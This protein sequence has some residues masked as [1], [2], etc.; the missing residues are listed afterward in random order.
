MVNL[1]GTETNTQFA[2]PVQS[3]NHV[4]L[5]PECLALWML[6][7]KLNFKLPDTDPNWGELRLVVPG[8]GDP[9]SVSLEPESP[10]GHLEFES[11]VQTPSLLKCP[12][13]Y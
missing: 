12:L 7:K 2:L 4:S 10:A 5:P 6:H 13:I 9:D 8:A 3:I 1:P 11:G